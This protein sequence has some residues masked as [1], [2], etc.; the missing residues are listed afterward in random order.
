MSFSAVKTLI[1]NTESAYATCS[2]PLFLINQG[3]FIR[4]EG[5]VFGMRDDSLREAESITIFC[6]SES[7]LFSGNS[8]M[9][10]EYSYTQEVQK[11]KNLVFIT[12]NARSLNLDL[13]AYPILFCFA[14][15]CWYVYYSILYLYLWKYPVYWPSSF[16]VPTSEAKNIL[17]KVRN[18]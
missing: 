5:F 15:L 16:I 11:K 2:L 4:Q 6:G 17:C 1:G 18:L 3:S 8:V 9:G 14:W 12:K 13:S 10:G 7:P